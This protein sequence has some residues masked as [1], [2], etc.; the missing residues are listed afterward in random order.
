MVGCVLKERLLFSCGVF[1]FSS[2]TRTHSANTYPILLLS[3]KRRS[4]L[5]I[6]EIQEPD[7]DDSD[8][9]FDESSDAETITDSDLDNDEDAVVF[10][11]VF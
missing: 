9:E 11:H 3:K 1:L 10:V 7:T 2:M 4:Q 5:A 6:A 8:L